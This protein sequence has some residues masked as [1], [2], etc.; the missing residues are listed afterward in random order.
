[1]GSRDIEIEKTDNLIRR[2][3]AF[4]ERR[5]SL[6]KKA[7]ELSILCDA[8]VGVIVFSST[9]KLYEFSRPSMEHILSRYGAEQQQPNAQPPPQVV[10]LDAAILQEEMAK[11][12]S[13]YVRM[14]GKELNG[15]QIKELKDLEN[16]LSEAILA[17]KT[18]KEQVLVDQ[19]EKSRFQ[20]QMAMAEI[21]DLRK[22]LEEL[23]N[24]RNSEL[25]L[26]PAY[27][28]K[29]RS[30]RIKSSNNWEVMRLHSAFSH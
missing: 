26:S 7:K 24:K 19:L 5:K 28:R 1:M 18:K 14:I 25:G 8:E 20:E 27:V 17:V 30:L 29:K 15:L 9:G 13:A 6:F 22:Q 23:K 12:R 21:E 10:E 2:Q 11:L 16:Q 4:S 3:V